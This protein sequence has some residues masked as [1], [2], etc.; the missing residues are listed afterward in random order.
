M[1]EDWIEQ[2]SSPVYRETFIEAGSRR[3]F[4][5]SACPL[6]TPSELA[7]FALFA[8]ACDPPRPTFLL[9]LKGDIPQVTKSESES[10]SSQ[11]FFQMEILHVHRVLINQTGF[12]FVP[13]V[14]QLPAASHA[15]SRQL[16]LGIAFEG[17]AC[18]PIVLS[19]HA[20]STS[21]AQ[22]PRPEA[23]P[24]LIYM[25]A[26]FPSAPLQL[27]LQP[28]QTIKFPISPGHGKTF[29]GQFSLSASLF[30]GITYSVLSI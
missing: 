27:D 18:G 10:N 15:K 13:S 30:Q 21:A 17:D 7:G 5:L 4:L 29:I 12:L 23:Q 9:I 25:S 19:M 8:R 6:A 28:S 22:Q 26:K 3:A 1:D 14:A 11:R 2:G 24:P 20:A 16:Y